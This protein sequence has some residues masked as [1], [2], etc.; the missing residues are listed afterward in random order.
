MAFSAASSCPAQLQ[1]RAGGPHW[2]FKAEDPGQKQL[3]TLWVVPVGIQDLQEVTQGLDVLL[4]PPRRYLLCYLNGPW[5]EVTLERENQSDTQDPAVSPWAREQLL[6]LLLLHFPTPN[7]TVADM[8]LLCATHQDTSY[9]HHLTASSPSPWSEALLLFPSNRWRHLDWNLD[10]LHVKVFIP[11]YWPYCHC[12][13][14][15]P[16]PRQYELPKLQ[17]PRSTCTLQSGETLLAPAYTSACCQRLRNKEP[18]RL[19]ANPH[20]PGLMDQ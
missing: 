16:H 1:P 19:L 20:E 4:R 17:G 3:Q 11:N 14:L 9:T 15:T 5:R 12:C 8:C 10:L 13:S 2:P 6:T 18:Q 7:T